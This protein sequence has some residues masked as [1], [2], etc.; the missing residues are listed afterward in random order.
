MEKFSCKPRFGA[1]RQGV[2]QGRLLMVCYF[3]PNGIATIFENIA[4]WQRLSAYEIVVLN[5]WP[6]RGGNLA[7]PPTIS[8]DDF[9]GLLIHSTVSY[10]LHNIATLDRYLDKTIREYEGLKI[11]MKQDEQVRTN[12]FVYYIRDAGIDLVVTCV[13]PQELEKV[14]PSSVVGQT[15]FL[16]A[17]TGY[18]SPSMLALRD[19]F[20]NNSRPLDVSYRGSIQ[21]LQFGRLGFEKRKIASDF[22]R[23]F[24]QSDLRLDISSRWEDRI[25]G[26]EWFKFLGQS[27]FVLGAE[28]GSNLF[29]FD[30]QVEIWCKTYTAQTPEADRDDDEFYFNAHDAFLS[31]FE[32][33]INY[34][35]ISPRHFEA[36]CAGTTQILYEGH[37]SGI[38]MPDRHFVPLKR[39]FSNRD[40]VLESVRDDQKAALM[41]EAVF[42][43]IVSNRLNHYD[44]FVSN[45]DE[46]LDS[47]ECRKNKRRPGTFAFAGSKRRRVLILAAH[48]PILDPRLEWF[49]QS[50][51]KHFDVCELGT[52]RFG[53][54]GEGPS[55][56]VLSPARLRV[57]V[58][59]SR[60]D[61]SWVPNS[62]DPFS[63]PGLSALL[64]LKT[65]LGM[66]QWALTQTIGAIDYTEDDLSRFR[67]LCRY[68]VDS[69]G[70]LIEAARNLG[71]FDA[72][73]SCDL[74]T[75]PSST[76]L[77]QEWDAALLYDAHEYWP[78]S[79]LDFRSWEIEFW[80]NLESRLCK[81]AGKRI[82][83]SPHIARIL[84]TEYGAPFD[85]VPNCTLLQTGARV[86]P[87]KKAERASAQ[88]RAVKFLYQGNF[89]LGRGLEDLIGAWQ[90]V[91]S[92]ATLHLR[93]PD[94]IHRQAYISLAESLGLLNRNVFFPPAVTEDRLVEGA[95]E[96]DVGIVPYS[97]TNVNNKYAS[98]NKL[99]QYMA[100]GLAILCNDLPF[101]RQVVSDAGAGVWADFSQRASL[102]TAIDS[103][104]NNQ[105]EI[106]RM[107]AAAQKYFRSAFHWEYVS[108][109]T[110]EW[111]RSQV[112]ARP[113]T[114]QKP[115]NLSWA[116]RASLMRKP[117]DLADISALDASKLAFPSSRLAVSRSAEPMNFVTL[118]QHQVRSIQTGTI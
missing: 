100:A 78:Y 76:A 8:L 118:E 98:P 55:V 73:I 83:V 31:Q 101:V 12:E 40:A 7:I 114:E 18:I 66:P 59:R 69:N 21:P 15:K 116:G 112:S 84:E 49:A 57:R 13:P 91:T 67:Q 63:E 65:F 38:F 5:L 41:R 108:R 61:W 72:I 48:D 45:F 79:Y 25:G 43:E 30:G 82:T 39:D 85:C 88:T 44:T 58:E 37:Y 34:A 95:S 2:R 94:N 111:I 115:V 28:S 81:E 51:E 33:N 36:A 74:E 9:D 117:A 24:G 89:A 10:F 75:L 106:I 110:I 53:E 77:A 70:A 99:S 22:L 109:D 56:E 27:K 104:A 11:L 1:S 47:I 60:H 80:S 103:L 107:G 64:M 6:G 105:V 50:L 14:Y 3:D 87:K 46:A 102:A 29:D 32:S 54:V 97:P 86:T 23:H 71:H 52:Y 4:L 62:G 26:H 17:Y 113:E 20:K 96:A 90:F 16:T 92:G 42:D 35:Q 19:V 68:F 93:G